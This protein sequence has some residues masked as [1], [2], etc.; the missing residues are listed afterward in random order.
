LA[1]TGERRPD[2]ECPTYDETHALERIT[3]RAAF[4]SGVA[5]HAD[6]RIRGSQSRDPNS[7]VAEAD[8]VGAAVARDVG[9]EPRML[10]DAPALGQLRVVRERGGVPAV[11]RA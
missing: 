3:R 2:R 7:V 10:F 5:A 6:A 8:D 11:D 9:Q 4:A 1:P